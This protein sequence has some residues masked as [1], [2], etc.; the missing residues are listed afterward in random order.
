MT[1]EKTGVY[2]VE[3]RDHAIGEGWT[4]VEANG[5]AEAALLAIDRAA[6]EPLERDGDPDGEAVLIVRA[7]AGFGRR[8]GDDLADAIT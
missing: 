6:H 8:I 4:T 1:D 2:T 7:V 3:F 5:A